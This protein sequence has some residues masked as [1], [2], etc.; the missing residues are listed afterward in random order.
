M[1]LGRQT[2][3]VRLAPHGGDW[4]EAGI[5]RRAAELNQQAFTLIETFH[6][7]PLPLRG[8]FA[9]DAGGDVVLSVVKG[10]EDGG[11][12]ARAYETAGNAARATLDVLG[13]RVEADF[14]PHEIKTFL[15]RDGSAVE[16]D[17]LES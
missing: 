4:R 16:T 13:T 5:V 3:R 10:A 17:L 15:L 7:G 14:G 1:D 12:A 6:E 9:D 2:F 8:S 11:Y